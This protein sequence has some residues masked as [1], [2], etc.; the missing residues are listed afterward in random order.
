[1]KDFGTFRIEDFKNETVWNRFLTAF[2]EM[3]KDKLLLQCKNKRLLTKIQTFQG[4]I[5][6]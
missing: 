4:V 2:N 1:M 5:Q 3:K 6:D